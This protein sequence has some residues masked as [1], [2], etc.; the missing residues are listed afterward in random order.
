MKLIYFSWYLSLKIIVFCFEILVIQSKIKRR[1]FH[2]NKNLVWMKKGKIWRWRH[3]KI[4]LKHQKS[5]VLCDSQKQ[6]KI[7]SKN[8]LS[9]HDVAWKMEKR[10]HHDMMVKVK[11]DEGS[12]KKQRKMK[13]R[14]FRW[15]K[16]R[17]F[18][19]VILKMKKKGERKTKNHEIQISVFWEEASY[20]RH[21]ALKF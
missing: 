13:W 11:M 1:K 9:K 20:L 8:H 21:G 2:W 19:F 14:K 6:L 15:V 17:R 12:K 18:L 5:F 10:K 3:R 7:Y 4:L 16:R